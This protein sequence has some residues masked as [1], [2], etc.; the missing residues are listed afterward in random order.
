MLKI[1]ALSIII[2]WYHMVSYTFNMCVS[3][4]CNRVD[5][6]TSVVDFNCSDRHPCAL[7]QL[8]FLV[9]GTSTGAR[10]KFKWCRL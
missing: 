9:F 2:Y 1:P 3:I 6:K 7:Q 10:G 5:M 4:N 8:V